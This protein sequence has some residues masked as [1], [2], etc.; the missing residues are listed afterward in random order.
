MTTPTSPLY[1]LGKLASQLPSAC[2]FKGTVWRV[3]D[4]PGPYG[5]PPHLGDIYHVETTGREYVW[6]GSKWEELGSTKP[7]KIA[8]LKSA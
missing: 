3:S 8:P 2:H 6:S 5:H 1:D 4:L 7:L